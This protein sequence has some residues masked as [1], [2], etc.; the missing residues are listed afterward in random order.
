[1][2]AGKRFLLIH[3]VLEARTRLREALRSIEYDASVDIVRTTH[4]AMVRLSHGVEFTTVFLAY[5][6]TTEPLE[7]FL[8]EVRALNQTLPFFIVVLPNPQVEATH[9]AE[10]FARGVDGFIAEPYSSVELEDLFGAIDSTAA[11]GEGATVSRDMRLLGFLT[12]RLQLKLDEVADIQATRQ[13][14]IE[15]LPKNFIPLKDTLSKLYESDPAQFEKVLLSRYEEIA[16]PKASRRKVTRKQAEEVVHPGVRIKTL[17]NQRN[18]DTERILSL[19]DI[20]AEEL[21]DLLN[22]RLGVDEGL[23][24]KLARALG[25]TA[26]YWLEMQERFDKSRGNGE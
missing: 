4:E 7:A 13:S 3:P 5:N 23:A 21:S 8:A 10:L 24:G 11:A 16:P 18:I 1:M 22:G 20:S 12:S 15:K 14:V 19:L 2:A 6:G 25:E 17:L 26:R 9:V